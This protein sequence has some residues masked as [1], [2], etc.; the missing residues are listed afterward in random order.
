LQF[1]EARSGSCLSDIGLTAHQLFGCGLAVSR[2]T[3]PG[4]QIKLTDNN[5]CQ[6]ME[7]SDG[8]VGL[9]TLLENWI[10]KFAAGAR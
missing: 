7:G 8:C 2:R 9:P 1:F 4:P 10:G 3:A 6:R 5:F